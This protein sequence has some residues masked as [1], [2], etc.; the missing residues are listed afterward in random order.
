MNLSR[1]VV[2]YKVFR[3]IALDEESYSVQLELKHGL[4][5]EESEQIILQAS[6]E[7]YLD[8]VKGSSPRRYKINYE[9]LAEDWRNL[10]KAEAG[11][12]PVT[13]ENFESFLSSYAK[14]YMKHEKHSTIREMMVEDFYL[15]LSQKASDA[16][17]S[18]DL[19]QLAERLGNHLEGKRPTER[20]IEH[21][22][23]HR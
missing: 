4:D 20:H 10:W 3:N 19:K 18:N 15:G 2:A 17:L 8:V 21:A 22:L 7:G 1:S 16:Y 11:E 13:P 14:S 5:D 6:E 12:V 9:K 23:N